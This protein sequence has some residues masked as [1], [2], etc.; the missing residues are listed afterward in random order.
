VAKNPR[1]DMSVIITSA[2]KSIRRPREIAGEEKY[3]NSSGVSETAGKSESAKTSVAKEAKTAK[4]SL[5]FLG[6]KQVRIPPTTGT[7]TG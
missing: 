6:V 2:K 4:N 7:K 1:K 5:I 3:S